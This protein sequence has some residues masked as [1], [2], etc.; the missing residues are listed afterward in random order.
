ML[1]AVSKKLDGYIL[2]MGHLM[3]RYKD[4]VFQKNI[5]ENDFI[6]KIV[7]FIKLGFIPDYLLNYQCEFT[8][9]DQAA[10]AIF[11]I[12]TYSNNTNR[13]FH[14][15]NNHSVNVKRLLKIFKKYN[16]NI[17]IVSENDFK[18]QIQNIL[19]DDNKKYL[20]Y[21]LMND[22][23]NELHLNYNNEIIYKSKFTNRYLRKL[24][25]KWSK[26]SN[27][28]LKRFINLIRKEL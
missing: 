18:T 20:I 14:L 28:Y 22:F 8:P 4:G 15:Y 2:R 27:K 7:T 21:Y 26:I 6:R 17:K 12:V 9:V 5:S 3:P 1:E 13:I 16:N 11:K 23:D 25:F 19:A 24:L 10:Q